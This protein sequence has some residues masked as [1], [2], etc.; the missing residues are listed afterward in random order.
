[1]P[2]IEIGS[3]LILILTTSMIFIFLQKLKLGK[4]LRFG[5]FDKYISFNGS[6]PMAYNN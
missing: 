1:M 2:L 6:I 4:S 5:L 3:S